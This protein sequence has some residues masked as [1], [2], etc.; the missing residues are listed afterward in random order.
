MDGMIYKMILRQW[1]T[2]GLNQMSPGMGGF[3]YQ[4]TGR[5]SNEDWPMRKSKSA[6]P[7]LI[8]KQ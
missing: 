3:P 2:G 6:N 1:G 4:R 7:D 8:K 5:G